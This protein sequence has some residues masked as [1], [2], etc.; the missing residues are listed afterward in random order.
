MPSGLS[1]RPSVAI[2]VPVYN[3]EKYLAECLDSIRAQDYDRWHA[4]VVID[5]SPDGSEEIAR[6][7]EATDDRFTVVSVPNGG[8]GSARNVGMAH[9]HSDYVF[10]VDSDDIVPRGTITALVEAAQGT[11]SEIV[12]GYAEDFGEA[13]IP[14]RYWT[15]NGGLYREGA[16]TVSAQDDPRVLDDHVVWNKL[17][18][19]AHLERHGLDFPAGV[20][21]EDMNF[22]ARAAL[23][24]S[25]VSFV[26]RLV[27]RHRRHDQAISASYTRART[28]HDWLGQ[29][30]R[31]IESV[32]DLGG[33][34]AL[35][36]YLITFTHSQWWTRARAVD[37]IDDASALQ[38][39]CELSK[40]VITRLD[41]AGRDQ[42][43]P[44]YCAL[45]E[46]FAFGSPALFAGGAIGVLA[47]P[48]RIDAGRT[49]EG[50]R[51]VL[52]AITRLSEGTDA[53][54]RI[55]EALVVER[56]FRPV[57]DGHLE[58]DQPVVDEALAL[59]DRFSGVFL[60]HLVG[61]RG[62]MRYRLEKFMLEHGY[63]SAQ[64]ASVRRDERG[65]V[66]RGAL[67]PT[68]GA[69]EALQATAVV[70]DVDS[71]EVV[72][73]PMTW[74]SLADPREWRW[75]VVLPIDK[76]QPERS[77]R[78]ELR[79][80]GED[81]PRGR[82]TAEPVP[83]GLHDVVG[84]ANTVTFPQSFFA[85][86]RND[87]RIFMFPAWRDNPYTTTLQLELFARGYALRGTSN[88]D[89]FIESL[90]SPFRRGVIHIQWPSLVTDEAE[91][92]LDA[93]RRVHDVVGA[94]RTAKT[95]GRP[96]IWTVHNVLPH[97][98]EYLDAAVRLHQELAD[99]ADVVHVLNSQ[100]AAVAAPY[101]RIDPQK[102]VVIPHP[103]YAGVYGAAMERREARDAIGASA[104]RIG[105]LFFGQLRPYKGLNHLVDAMAEVTARRQ[106]VELL[107][108]GKPFAGMDDVIQQLDEAGIPNTRHVGFVPDSDVPAWLSSA[109]VLVLP[110]R[111]VLNSG[112]LYLGATFGVPTIL[113]DESHLRA[114]FGDQRWVRFFDPAAPSASMA[115]LIDSEWYRSEDVRRAARAFAD[116]HR[117]IDVSRRFAEVVE[118]LDESAG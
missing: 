19:R 113:P 59:A 55:A 16:V 5:G 70:T 35:R 91:S 17:Y 28:L 118:R 99:L 21:C 86:D 79:F 117:P 106:D 69:H 109:D 32:A 12:A 80:D 65:I 61:D 72:Y 52:D 89:A 67:V 29:S 111:K 104:E 97:D 64:I 33:A 82:G 31:T 49:P 108:A 3:V 30:T 54:R 47:N 9:S 7:Y 45:L 62:S 14:S 112:T 90:T 85:V 43:G 8:L 13:W 40:L 26:P 56:V 34:D 73:P 23:T 46:F 95:L 57:A 78:I 94:L 83:Q 92:A 63:V 15:Q 75:Q 68:R 110:H 77:Y 22:S 93:E 102:V 44:W 84:P 38:G 96:I 27:Y 24:A 39:L 1:S 4:T 98:T 116:A 58:H 48:L 50:A 115:A 36:H 101:Y 81:G 10:F 2:I 66:V 51:G 6:R 103:S 71:N 60:T 105:V 53:D 20:H 76:V 74:T 42:L 37:E 107:L 114:D 41:E 100:T 25:S 11:G 18:L 88:L 87:K